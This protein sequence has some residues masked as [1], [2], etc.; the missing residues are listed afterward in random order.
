MSIENHT[1]STGPSSPER[2]DMHMQRTVNSAVDTVESMI[3]ILLESPPGTEKDTTDPDWMPP[4]PEVDAL[5][6]LPDLDIQ[7]L[8]DDTPALLQ[9]FNQ[10]QEEM[11]RK[12]GSDPIRLYIY[13]ISQFP[14]LEREEETKA[15]K[16]MEFWLYR[17]RDLWNM[18]PF[19]QQETITLLEEVC[20]GKKLIRSVIDLNF[21][22]I[23]S[24]E[25]LQSL[26]DALPV[27]RNLRDKIKTLASGITN[28][29]LNGH[30]ESATTDLQT[31]IV[32]CAD[33]L[34]AFP[35]KHKIMAAPVQ[36][37]KD[38]RAYNLKDKDVFEMTGDHTEC[39]EKRITDIDAACDEW[40]RGRNV[41]AQGNLRLVISIAKKYRMRGM[42]F[43]D[44][45]QHGNSGL[46]HAIDKFDYK[47]GFKFSTYATWWI[48]QAITRALADETRLVR[49]P[50]HIYTRLGRF[51]SMRRKLYGQLG[52]EPTN[53]ELAD[54]LEIDLE[55]VSQMRK[56]D[57]WTTSLN[58][59][60]EKMKMVSWLIS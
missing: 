42:H 18:S 31:A 39:L 17:Q 3:Q 47:R 60:A 57:N 22:V 41:L 38:L 15:S 44:L 9:E 20:E 24:A 54:T 52:R 14:L 58:S 16:Y 4:A 51:N 25:K 48:R 33:V 36:R 19:L 10:L 37:L 45:I 35:I 11:M 7:K 43:L 30:T 26:K 2:K 32:E 1:I 55:Q 8:Q 13:Q 29:N 23:N 53:E 56:V 5:D 40:K 46:M 12:G 49:L 34:K 28:G 6:D 59:P 27:L 50:V 21:G